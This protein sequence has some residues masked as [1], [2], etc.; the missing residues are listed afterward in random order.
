MEASIDTGTCALRLRGRGVAWDAAAGVG[1][2]LLFLL[3]APS[4]G[5]DA[6]SIGE[7][8]VARLA[9]TGKGDRDFDGLSDRRERASERRRRGPRGI[10]RSGSGVSAR[11]A[12][13][14]PRPVAPLQR[15]SSG[16][17]TST[18]RVGA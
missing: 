8:A 2:G 4:A 17:P 1:L 13:R 12:P 14:A 18:V 16:Y 7:R 15:L 11:G 3:A 9:A 6:P 5:A 10:G